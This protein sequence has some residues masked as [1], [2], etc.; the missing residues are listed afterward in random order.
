MDAGKRLASFERLIQKAE[1][2]T[3]L[4]YSINESAFMLSVSRSTIFNL[5]NDKK[6]TIIKIRGRTLIPRESLITLIENGKKQ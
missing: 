2:A 4:A 6:L 1:R 5:I 3:R